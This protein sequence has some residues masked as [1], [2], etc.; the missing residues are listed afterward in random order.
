VD[1]PYQF[2]FYDGGGLDIAFLSAVEVDPRSNV[3]ISR[4]AGK[5]VGVGG[6]I[7]ISQNAR[8]MVFG[9]TLTA[10]GLRIETGDGKL[11]IAQEGRHHKFVQQVGQISYNGD[12][13]R[14]RGQ[15]TVFVTER[16]VFRSSERGLELSEVAPG[17]DLQRDVLD[18]MDFR[19]AIA[20]NLRTMD[21]R[22]FRSGPMGLA[23]SIK[24]RTRRANE[25]LVAAG[26]A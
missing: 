11:R 21:E 18:Q 25:R 5:I 7:N 17:I 13:A 14:E 4:F 26:L 19:P 8:K 10:G 22:I 16:A 12:Y 23:G 24:P 20:Q 6:F 1:Q 15:Q 2:D 3:N 9:G